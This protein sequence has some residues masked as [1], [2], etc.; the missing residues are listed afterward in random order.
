M[1][2]VDEI[3][4]D[5]S[6]A[7]ENTARV[8]SWRET[9]R[10][11]LERAVS[12]WSV[13]KL[14]RSVAVGNDGMGCHSEAASKERLGHSSSDSSSSSSSRECS[15]NASPDGLIGDGASVKGCGLKSSGLTAT[16]ASVPPDTG[17]GRLR[18]RKR[19]NVGRGD[20]NSVMN[21]R[22]IGILLLAPENMC[23]NETHAKF[24]FE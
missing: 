23:R 2:C 13:K 16:T 10:S 19:R 3:T 11:L 6:G 21:V 20:V 18:G 4:T 22:P 9:T 17:R 5:L 8:G 14:F 1:P 15:R 12:D 7:G 24:F